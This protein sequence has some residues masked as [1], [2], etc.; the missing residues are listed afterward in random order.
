M[1]I[2][3]SRGESGAVTTLPVMAIPQQHDEITRFLNRKLLASER[4]AVADHLQTD[5]QQIEFILPRAQEVLAVAQSGDEPPSIRCRALQL[6]TVCACVHPREGCER[7]ILSVV[8][9][10]SASRTVRAAGAILLFQLP[11]SNWDVD[12]LM[13][14][15][16]H[17]SV[18]ESF[19]KE[20]VETSTP[21]FLMVPDKGVALCRRLLKIATTIDL[22][23]SVRSAAWN[24]LEFHGVPWITDNDAWAFLRKVGDAAMIQL[25]D[26]EQDDQVRRAAIGV[27]ST[28]LVCA[29]EQAAADWDD[30]SQ[31]YVKVLSQILM[32]DAES[33]DM[34]TAAVTV[35]R[36]LG[37]SVTKELVSAFE[38]GLFTGGS[39]T[40]RYVM[41]AIA[42]CDEARDLWL[43]VI[44]RYIED[45]T[46]DPDVRSRANAVRLA[47]GLNRN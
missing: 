38:A 45:D 7:A 34:R 3:C 32:N 25:L 4:L 41:D 39:A 43:P 42:G 20:A 33:E 1:V 10:E 11:A 17:N 18:P 35:C 13:D 8:N 21:L 29:S 24:A 30:Y 22:R 40:Q 44:D 37:K 31:E 5:E 14:I 26:N 47:G 2:G 23:S 12:Y 28:I 16:L 36:F 9:D 46:R 27:A 19:Q 6:L 15:V